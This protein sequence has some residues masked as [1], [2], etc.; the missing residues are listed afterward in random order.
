MH[1]TEA[2][3]LSTEDLK[4]MHKPRYIA[5]DEWT[6]ASGISWFAARKD[7][8]IWIQHSGAL[9]G[10][11][12]NVCFD[13]KSAVGTIALING[14][15][16]DPAAFA[17]GLAGSAREVALARAPELAP[18]PVMPAQYCPL[19]GAYRGGRHVCCPEVA[20]RQTHLRQP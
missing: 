10:Y 19:L 13:P 17:M 4:E 8:A 7:D 1:A 3:V 9:P 16:G 15:D 6:S 2:H 12:T 20:R 14:G 18:P 11:R 5:D